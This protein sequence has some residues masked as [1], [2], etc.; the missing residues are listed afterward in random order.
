[1]RILKRIFKIVKKSKHLTTLTSIKDSE[2]E[3]TKENS[4]TKK[5]PKYVNNLCL[6]MD[7]KIAFTN[8]S[9]KLLTSKQ[10][11]LINNVIPN[12]GL[13]FSYTFNYYLLNCGIKCQ[14]YSRAYQAQAKKYNTHVQL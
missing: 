7:N 8:S 9:V 3:N 14:I 2:N 6:I 4:P 10:T 1:M 12:K 11:L 5:K 13:C